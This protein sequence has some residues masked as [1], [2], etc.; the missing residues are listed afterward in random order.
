MD[1]KIQNLEPNYRRIYSDILNRNFPHKLEKCKALLQK[2]TLSSLDI[3]EL[4]QNIF[5]T[6]DKQTEIFN[7]KH[8]SYNEGSIRHMLDYQ[9]KYQ[10]N[11]TQLAFHFK[12]SRN[13]VA[14]W[15]KMFK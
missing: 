3:L 12:L 6:S 11:N 13:S 1:Q 7:K 2:K 15:K 8:R 9:K 14:K 5:G 4:N 10:L